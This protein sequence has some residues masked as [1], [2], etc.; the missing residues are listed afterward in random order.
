MGEGFD[1]LSPSPVAARA[2]KKLHV[3]FDLIVVEAV[4]FGNE[5]KA[6]MV[7]ECHLDKLTFVCL[8]KFTVFFHLKGL[9]LNVFGAYANDFL[10]VLI[11]QLRM[12]NVGSYA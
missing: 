8:S 3:F 11:L 1:P 4:C 7:T 2:Y 6:H 9:E 12:H 10:F 5:A